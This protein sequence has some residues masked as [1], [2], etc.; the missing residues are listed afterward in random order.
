MNH[1]TKMKK[2][3]KKLINTCLFLSVKKKKFVRPHL[4]RKG[5]VVVHICHSSDSRKPTIE[6]H[7]PGQSGQNVRPYSPN[8]RVKNAIEHLLSKHKVLSLKPSTAKKV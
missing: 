1:K 8:N 7:G 4:N 2:K 3:K 6:A 5:S